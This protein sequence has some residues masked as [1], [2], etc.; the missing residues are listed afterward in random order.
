M[1]VRQVRS[2]LNTTLNDATTRFNEQRE[3]QVSKRI[4]QRALYQERYNRRVFKK[5][6]RIREVNR[7]KRENVHCTVRGQWDKLIFS[8]ESQV[9]VETII[10]FIF[11]GNGTKPNPEIAYA[12]LLRG[13][14]A[15]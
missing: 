13:N 15:L 3:G 8:D 11:G 4:A 2:D 6:V 10:A 12:H 7:K 9:M 5:K 14:F 1:L